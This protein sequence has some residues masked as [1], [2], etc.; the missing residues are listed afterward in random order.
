MGETPHAQGH[1]EA[2]IFCCWVY[3]RGLIIQWEKWDEDP[4]SRWGEW[5]DELV[6]HLTECVQGG[7]V[8]FR[9]WC[10]IQ[11]WKRD[12]RVR[13]VLIEMSEVTRLRCDPAPETL[14]QASIDLQGRNYQLDTLKQNERLWTLGLDDGKRGFKPQRSSHLLSLG[15]LAWVNGNFEHGRPDFIRIINRPMG[16]VT[17]EVDVQDEVSGRVN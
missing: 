10:R 15:L 6:A 2:F 5:T 16:K 4:C 8:Y 14:L 3:W 12:E 7:V 1:G 11:E 13:R 17:Y 9:V